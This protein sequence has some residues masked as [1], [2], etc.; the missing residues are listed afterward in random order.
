[1]GI[2]RVIF[3]CGLCLFL[4]GMRD[5]FQPP[6]TCQL[7]QLNQ[8]QFRGIIQSGQA[9]GLLHDAD[10]RWHRVAAGDRLPTGWRVVSVTLD[11]LQIS[12][13][14]DCIP[15]QWRW[16]REGTQYEKMDSEPRAL[17]PVLHQRSDNAARHA[18]R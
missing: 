10:G 16:K 9:V 15:A 4:S 7:A 5:P 11:E 17:R 2:K 3:A 13:G 8:W 12:T 14:N 1:M 6:D 18:N